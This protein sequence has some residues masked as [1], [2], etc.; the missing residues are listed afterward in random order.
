MHIE[1]TG[2]A[3]TLR[4]DLKALRGI[5]HICD[6]V[7]CAG[8]TSCCACYEVVVSDAEQSAAV[9]WLGDAMRFAS[10]LRHSEVFEESSDGETV[11]AADE[12]GLCAFAYRSKGAVWCSLHA[13]ALKRGYDPVRVKPFSCY[14]WPLALSED[15]IP[16]LAVQDGAFDFPCNRRRR[17]K[18]LH[19]GIEDI[20]RRCFGEPSLEQIRLAL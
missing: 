17:G 9:G 2:F 4:A 8:Q 7:L 18:G 6:P 15:D 11:L 13:A 14:L 5:A 20:I 3:G 10:R 16:V 12:N 1:I 19:A